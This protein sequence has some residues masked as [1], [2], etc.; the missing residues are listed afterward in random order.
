MSDK[1]FLTD[2][3]ILRERARHHMDQGAVT[4]GYHADRGVVL[5]VLNT[6]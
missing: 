5:K 6:V 3:K 2:I 1:P 4:E